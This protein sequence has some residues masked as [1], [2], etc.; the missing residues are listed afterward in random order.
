M[1][2]NP[3]AKK[4]ADEW[5][6]AQGRVAEAAED[7]RSWASRGAAPPSALGMGAAAGYI[8]LADGGFP[9]QRLRQ[10]VLP[11]LKAL[12]SAGRGIKQ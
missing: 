4:G 2:R 11:G 1:K 12:P 10:R 6:E 9:P 8:P 3:L 5:G 7:L